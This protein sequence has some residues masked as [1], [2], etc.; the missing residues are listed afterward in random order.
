ML[1][2]LPA[3]L[4]GLNLH[5]KSAAIDTDHR[6]L[7]PGLGQPNHQQLTSTLARLIL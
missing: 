1:K 2:I 5:G 6:P 3:R 4:R 7:V